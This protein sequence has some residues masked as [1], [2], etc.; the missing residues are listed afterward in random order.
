VLSYN[1]S[2][3]MTQLLGGE[4]FIKTKGELPKH[5]IN[6][7]STMRSSYRKWNS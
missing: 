5:M 3:L 1:H 4:Y 2:Q 7:F 6:A